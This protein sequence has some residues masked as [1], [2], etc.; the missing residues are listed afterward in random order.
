M[1]TIYT[2]TVTS[3]GGRHGRVQSADGALKVELMPPSNT[4]QHP[5]RT[6]PEQLFAAGYAACFSS[7]ME[8]VAK[9]QKLIHGL[10]TIVARVHLLSGGGAFG[11]GVDMDVTVN[12]LT[13]AEAEQLVTEAHKVCPYSVAT[14]NNIEVAFTVRGTV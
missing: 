4:V 9:A 6:N 5:T 12:E 1:E 3:T 2:A 14:R 10:I 8:H 11:L 7:A 13:Q